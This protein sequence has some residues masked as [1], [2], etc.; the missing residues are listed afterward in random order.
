MSV[1]LRKLI[2]CLAALIVA[3]ASVAFI[4]QNPGRIGYEPLIIREA[5]LSLAIV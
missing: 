2:V 5:L 3:V 1:S 4:S